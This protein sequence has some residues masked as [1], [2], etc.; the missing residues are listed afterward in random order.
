MKLELHIITPVSRPYFLPEVARS[1]K[2]A[3]HEIQPIWYCSFDN[4]IAIPDPLPEDGWRLGYWGPTKGKGIYG[5]NCRNTVL[6][7]FSSG[8]IYFLDDD[9]L[10]HPRLESVFLAAL[11][12][13]PQAQWFVFH[14]VL[15]D[16]RFYLRATDQPRF[17][18]IDTGQCVLRRELIGEDRF[19]LDEY[20]ADGL[21]YTRLSEKCRPV[22]IPEIATYYNALRWYWST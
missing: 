8:W 5:N 2:S 3:F 21:L 4:G 20:A 15:L 17:G 7:M 9:N 1:I 6:D 22:A 10:I 13:Y 11:Q 19:Q 18:H 12:Q 14:Q 16:G